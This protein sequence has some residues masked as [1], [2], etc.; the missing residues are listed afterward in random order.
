MSNLLVFK[1]TGLSLAMTP[2][3][4]ACPSLVMVFSIDPRLSLMTVVLVDSRPSLMMVRIVRLAFSRSSRMA[5]DNVGRLYTSGSKSQIIYVAYL[6]A[7]FVLPAER[8]LRSYVVEE[9]Y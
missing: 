6:N 1:G 7:G 3:T 5:L 2:S 8:V 9:Q 4:D